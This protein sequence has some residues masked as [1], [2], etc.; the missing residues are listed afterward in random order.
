MRLDFGGTQNV[1][2]VVVPGRQMSGLPF[3]TSILAN[4][5][6][7]KFA[8]QHAD[9]DM[10]EK[11]SARFLLHITKIFWCAK[12]AQSLTEQELLT[13]TPQVGTE[14]MCPGAKQIAPAHLSMGTAATGLAAALGPVPTKACSTVLSSSRDT[15][16]MGTTLSLTGT[17]LVPVLPCRH[18]CEIW[19]EPVSTLERFR[20]S[21]LPGAAALQGLGWHLMLVVVLLVGA[22]ACPGA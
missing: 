8:V 17:H 2:K 9:A 1:Q 18:T 22:W 19:H 4:F 5:I 14:A 12:E 15:K 13:R 21:A 7:P 20:G 16:Y 10:D 6:N 11:R 3:Q